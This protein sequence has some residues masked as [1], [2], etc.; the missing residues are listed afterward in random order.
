MSRRKFEEEVVEETTTESTE[1]VSEGPDTHE[2]FVSIL[3]DMGLSAEQAEAVH[4]MAMDLINA[5]EGEV[6]ETT[7]VTEETKIE[8]RRARSAARA[9]RSEYSRSES[10]RAERRGD[11]NVGRRLMSRN[12]QVERMERRLTRLS[13][14]NRELRSRL[15]EFGQR[16][17][18][19]PLNNRPH[20]EAP[21]AGT[22][23]LAGKAGE[24]LAMIQ[25]FSNK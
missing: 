8:A 13:R 21:T 5:G 9:R 25:N 15:E 12:E 1:T 22:Q 23:P 14:Q 3:V 19:R 24:A 2:Q 4:S 16:P 20:H 10:P 7:E 6:T 11:R 18:A 17:A